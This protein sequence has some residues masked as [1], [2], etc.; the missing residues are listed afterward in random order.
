MDISNIH[1]HDTQILRVVE[2]TRNAMFTMEVNYPVD[3]E[4][5]HFEI[6]FLVFE[7]VLNYQI[8][9]GAVQGPPTILGAEVVG[10]DGRR[11]KLRLD[12][13]AGYRELSCA[14]VKLMEDVRAK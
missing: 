1:W 10:S 9:E 3:W 4:A 11:S 13:T 7:D 12:T 5:N 2:D 6:C 14:A 8:F